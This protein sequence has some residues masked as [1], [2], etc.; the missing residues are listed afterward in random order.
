MPRYGLGGWSAC[1]TQAGAFFRR[2]PSRAGMGLRLA[3]HKAAL[4]PGK[5]SGYDQQKSS[6]VKELIDE[7]DHRDYSTQPS[8]GG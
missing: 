8:R 7:A 3:L 2:V 1:P 4:E 5:G 6:T